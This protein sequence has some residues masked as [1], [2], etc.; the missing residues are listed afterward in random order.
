MSKRTKTL[1][2]ELLDKT[3]EICS[4]RATIFTESMKETVGEP[5]TVRRAKAFSD[6]LSGMSIYIREGDL[7]V[8]NQARSPR[9]APIFPEYSV[10][11]I[12]EELDG[13]PY[14]FEERPNDV[15]TIA[16]DAEEQI[17]EVIEYWRGKTTLK[18]LR[19]LLPEEANKAWDIGAIDE[20]WVSE[21]G[22]GNVLPDYEDLLSQGL[23][24][25]IEH[26]EDKLDELDLREPGSAKKKWFLESVIKS[27]RAVIDFAH[28][29]AN[30]LEEMAEEVKDPARRKE[31]EEMQNNCR[32]APENPAETFW[33]ALQAVWF[34]HLAIQIESNG[35]AISLGRFDQYLYPYYKKDIEKGR[36]TREEA[37]EL[38]EA[39]FV[40]ANE[41][42]KLRP[43]S[44]AKFF[45]GYHMAENLAIGGQTKDGQDAVNEVTNV[46]LDAT[47]NMGLPKPSV[48]LKWFEGASEEFMEEALKVVQEHSGG[49]PAFY[50][51][52]GVTRMLKNMG[53]AEEDL[54]NWAP[55]GCIEAS[56][57]G[58]WDFAAKGAW[59]NVAKILE[60]ILNG[61]EDPETGINLRPIEKDIR[62]FESG[63][64]ILET[65]KNPL[66][67]YMDLQVITEHMNDEVH[68]Q[69]DI[70]AFRS[71]LIEDTIERGKS[72]IEGGSVYSADG[73]PTVGSMTAGDS[74][75]AIEALVFEDKKLT[76]DELYHA[77]K[78][79]FEDDGTYPTG[80]EVRQLLWNK[81]PKF[82]NDD[83]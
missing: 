45:P 72:L 56:I 5:I 8:G 40:K 24:G 41:V 66:K 57:P 80:E 70:N 43:W 73:G 27:N 21:G 53:V 33:E 47:R 65:F 37:L 17:R 20:G 38:V 59:L 3:P 28:R 78:T 11:W 36:L 51:D 81:G 39:F 12:E 19:E 25:I 71:S 22:F 16:E 2:D 14:Y 13:E 83:D 31:L 55:V 9:A 29:F 75:A 42:N 4:E 34:I 23:K 67:Y 50:N 61:G 58:K 76:R 7:I 30:R 79:N 32:N 35:H 63:R 62:T 26:A 69:H 15:F 68:I 54:Y 77:L 82:G 1:R 6:V 60:L 52:K 18:N 64:E 49:M 44:G 46:V 74:I 48:S 10:E